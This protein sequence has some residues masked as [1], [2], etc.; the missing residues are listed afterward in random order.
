MIIFFFFYDFYVIIKLQYTVFRC[1]MLKIIRMIARH[2]AMVS[3]VLSIASFVNYYLLD[4]SMGKGVY[5]ATL[6]ASL[7]L[8][9]VLAV[10]MFFMLDNVDMPLNEVVDLNAANMYLIGFIL[11][12]MITLAITFNANFLVMFLCMAANGLLSHFLCKKHREAANNK[13]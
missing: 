7:Y 3:I 2:I 6:A 11:V 5:A 4:N 12:T 10:N 13:P 8:Q 9:F 1:P